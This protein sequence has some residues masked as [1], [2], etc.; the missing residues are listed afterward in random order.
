MATDI[1][2]T[3]HPIPWRNTSFLYLPWW[4]H[5]ILIKA[6]EEGKDWREYADP[7][8]ALQIDT[9]KQAYV[10]YG[11]VNFIESRNGYQY[12]LSEYTVDGPDPQPPLGANASTSCSNVK[13][14]NA[15][16]Y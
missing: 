13:S 14:T 3:V 12:T 1:W 16:A 9:L 8:Y 7:Q 2:T 11:E 5:N 4:I 10:D 6:K 15:K